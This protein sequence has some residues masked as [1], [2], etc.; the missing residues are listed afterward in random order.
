MEGD[1]ACIVV[2]VHCTS[3]RMQIPKSACAQRKRAPVFAGVGVHASVYREKG[4]KRSRALA[5]HGA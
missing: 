3:T 1:A 5:A 2:S 4:Q